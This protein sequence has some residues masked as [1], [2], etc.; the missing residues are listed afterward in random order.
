MVT[1]N[2]STSLIVTFVFI[3]FF[4]ADAMLPDAEAKHLRAGA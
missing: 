1:L 2:N 4:L 3:S